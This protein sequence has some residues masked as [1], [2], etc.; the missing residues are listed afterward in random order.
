MPSIHQTA[1]P[2]YPCCLSEIRAQANRGPQWNDLPWL[3]CYGMT[4]KSGPEKSRG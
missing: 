4:A 3:V 2:G 1:S